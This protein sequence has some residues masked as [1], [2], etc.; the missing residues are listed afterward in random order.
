MRPMHSA[1]NAPPLHELEKMA[2]ETFET[3][4][5]ALGW[6]RRPPPMLDGESPLAC[7]KTSIGARRVKDILVA[8]KYGS[9]A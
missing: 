6:L 1:D 3:E 9:V 5:A 4:E 8:I 7:A 2:N